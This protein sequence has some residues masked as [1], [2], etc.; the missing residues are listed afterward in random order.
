MAKIL[1]LAPLLLTA[2][3]T[4]DG[5][6]A[7]T[8]APQVEYSAVGRE[9][10]WALRLDRDRMTLTRQIAN[11]SISAAR[12]VAIPT[13]SGRRYATSRIVVDIAPGGCRDAISGSGFLDAVTIS[14]DGRT[15]RGCGGS[16]LLEDGGY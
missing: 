4:T 8:N 2:C 14:A 13:A 5:D 10:D 9:P 15:L 6:E 11:S 3:E 12:P 1:I 16:R 7:L